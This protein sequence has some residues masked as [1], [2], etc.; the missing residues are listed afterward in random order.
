M[1]YPFRDSLRQMC[2]R[3]L[4]ERREDINLPWMSLNSKQCLPGNAHL[5]KRKS[6]SNFTNTNKLIFLYLHTQTSTHTLF[7]KAPLN[8]CTVNIVQ[9]Q[10]GSVLDIAN[11]LISTVKGIDIDDSGKWDRNTSGLWCA[12]IF[13]KK[14]KDNS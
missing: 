7:S 14:K 5:R 1:A 4:R 2:G 3:S 9:L 10:D 12:M 13:F 11:F 8:K 6:R